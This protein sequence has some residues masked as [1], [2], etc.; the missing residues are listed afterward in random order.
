MEM[1]NQDLFLY[2]WHMFKKVFLIFS[3]GSTYP[4]VILFHDS[5]HLL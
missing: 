3:L 1:L 4:K 5:F 2:M